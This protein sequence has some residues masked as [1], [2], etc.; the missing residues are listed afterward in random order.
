MNWHDEGIII[1]LQPYGET[2]LVAELMTRA[3]G[4]HKGLVKGGRSRRQLPFLQVGNSVDAHWQARLAEHMGQFRLEAVRFAAAGLMQNALSLY[5]LQNVSEYLRL[6]PERDPHPALYDIVPLL[7]AHF[8]EPLLAGEIFMRFELRLLE[9]LGFGLDLSRC[10]AC[11]KRG[12]PLGAAAREQI[13]AAAEERVELAYVSPK[14]GRAVSRSAGAP[15]R[16]KL[17]PLPKFL[18]SLELRAADFAELAAASRLTGFFL[19]RNV[20]EARGR[21]PPPFR[22]VF[23]NSLQEAI[24]QKGKTA[25]EDGPAQLRRA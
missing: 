18:L 12:L 20:W 23:F 14:S 10:A 19:L 11:G 21:T 13:G 17:L 9:E 16:D 15:W 24:E 25:A 3:H 6:L 7:L 1:G 2:S 5:A 22:D 8:H 4:R